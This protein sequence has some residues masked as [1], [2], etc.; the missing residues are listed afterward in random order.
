MKTSLQ[1]VSLYTL[2][3][4]L[5]VGWLCLPASLRAQSEATLKAFTSDPH[6]GTPQEALVG[7]T[8]TN[9]AKDGTV[10]TRD[11]NGLMLRCDGFV[12]APAELFN[13]RNT[14]AGDPT[15][16]RQ[17]VSIVLHPGTNTQLTVNGRR[18]NWYGTISAGRQR[19]FLSYAV[20]KIDNLHC[21]AMRTLLP[22]VLHP[23]DNVTV[24]WSAWDEAA[25]KFQAVQTQ[26]VKIGKPIVPAP[27]SKT[28]AL[29]LEQSTRFAQSLPAMMPGALILGPEDLVVGLIA[30]GKVGEAMQFA[31]FKS[32]I[33]ATNCVT[34]LPTPDAT[35]Q[36]EEMVAVP[37]G[38]VLLPKVLQDLQLDLEKSR[39]ACVAPFLIDKY[40]VTN[41][42]Y[43]A[44]W[45]SLPGKM[46]NDPEVQQTLYPL[47]WGPPQSPFPGTIASVPVL[48]VRLAG[49]Q[50]YAKW[51]S[52]CL[53]L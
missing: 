38:P 47:G 27:D 31:N 37:G 14:T 53:A 12:L 10:Q 44:F 17:T 45:Q 41:G 50:A 43:L 6:L 16:P 20:L 25:Y 9:I 2:V 32:L 29:F 46:R 15:L 4:A 21:A 22:D 49:A 8:V 42:Q 19:Q 36:Q 34:P 39:V 48:G 35:F 33:L 1:R 23:D 40:E 7:I 52:G 13:T 11:G 51:A 3:C 5:L 26:T 30:G 24:A 28:P 18:P